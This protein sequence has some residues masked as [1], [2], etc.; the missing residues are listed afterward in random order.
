VGAR[1]RVTIHPSADVAE[2]AELGRGTR[3]W[4]QA[5]VRERAV[6]GAE[7][8]LGKGVY[9]DFG[10]RIGDRCKLQNGVYVFHGFELEDGV[11]LGPGAMLL[12]DKSPRAINPDGTLK[13]DADWTVSKGLIKHG[14]SV[15]GGAMVLPGVTV[16]RFAMVGTGALVT[17]DVPDHGLVYG[18]PARLHG[19]AC[20]CGHVAGSPTKKGAVVEMPCA[21]CGRVTTVPADVYAKVEARS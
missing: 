19:F 7:C 11:F 2:T 10:V 13:S 12:N 4:H 17:R 9:V 18:S 15:G 3:V 8:I 5:Q 20:E 1:E 16:G 6:I 14:A 21:E